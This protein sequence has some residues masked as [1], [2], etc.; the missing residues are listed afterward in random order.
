MNETIFSEQTEEQSKGDLFNLKNREASDRHVEVNK[1]Y[2]ILI[3]VVQFMAAL[4]FLIG[5]IFFFYNNLRYIAIWMFVIGSTF[6]I[7][8]PTIR[9]IREFHLAKLPLSSDDEMG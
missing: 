6:F 4:L 5:S 3:T 7:I 8:Q 9:L 1:I 2:E